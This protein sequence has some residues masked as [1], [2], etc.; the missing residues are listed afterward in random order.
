MHIITEA[1]FQG[2]LSIFNTGQVL[3]IEPELATKNTL[4]LFKLLIKDKKHYCDKEDRGQ[5]EIDDELAGGGFQPGD[6]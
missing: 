6:V 5:D 3:A 1:V 2:I 4:R